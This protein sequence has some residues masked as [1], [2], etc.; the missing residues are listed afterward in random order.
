MMLQTCACYVLSSCWEVAPM[1]VLFVRRPVVAEVLCCPCLFTFLIADSV[2]A[3]SLF[4][5]ASPLFCSKIRS[6]ESCSIDND[7]TCSQLTLSH[8]RLWCPRN[9]TPSV[10]IRTI[11]LRSRMRRVT[12]LTSEVIAPLGRFFV[13]VIRARGFDFQ[14]RWLE[15][16]D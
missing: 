11:N 1:D 15:R 2:A 12:G 8:C 4:N 7:A 3:V 9:D 14:E 5:T 10:V 13:A 6:K 16:R